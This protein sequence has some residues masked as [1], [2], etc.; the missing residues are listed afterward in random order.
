MVSVPNA[1][2][3]S[4]EHRVSANA[5]NNRVSVPI[6]VTPRPSEIISPLPEV[7]V[8]GEKPVYKQVLYSDYVKHFFAKPHDG[9]SV[10]IWSSP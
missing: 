9:K 6:F 7:L 4:S 3:K 8:S 10:G 2:N 1:S 5:S